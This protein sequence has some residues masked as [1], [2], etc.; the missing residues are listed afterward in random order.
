M[1][2]SC[3]APPPLLTAYPGAD[4]HSVPSAVGRHGKGR[5]HHRHPLDVRQPGQQGSQRQGPDRQA[6]QRT[7]VLPKHGQD[8]KGKPSARESEWRGSNR[9]GRLADALS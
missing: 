6:G 4:R 5:F 9:L 1:P 3:S 2:V 7:L 8:K